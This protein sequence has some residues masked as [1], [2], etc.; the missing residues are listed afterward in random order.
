MARKKSLLS[1]GAKK[2]LSVTGLCGGLVLVASVALMMSERRENV[3]NDGTVRNVLL[4]RNTREVSLDAV[5]TS[6]KKLARENHELSSQVSA[7]QEQL[8]R[9]AYRTGLKIDPAALDAR[10]SSLNRQLQILQD[11]YKHLS[12]GRAPDAG[13]GRNGR[14]S[15]FEDAETADHPDRNAGP[16]LNSSGN[17]GGAAAEQSGGNAADISGGA[18]VRSGSGCDASGKGDGHCAEQDPAQPSAA[19]GNSA[20]GR[21]NDEIEKILFSDAQQNTA[22][23][24]GAG[25]AGFSRHRSRI[26]VYTADGQKNP[27][28]SETRQS[29][30]Q[31][32]YPGSS[33]Y[34][35]RG[36]QGGLFLPAGSIL[37]GVFLNGMD[38]PTGQGHG[39]DQFPAL[40]RLKKEA[41]LP[42]R[43]RSDIRECFLIVSGY[44]DLSSERAYLRGELISCITESRKV[45]EGNI[46]AYV[47]GPDGFA[48]VRGRL[49]SKQGQ[50]IAKS[51]MSGFLS[52]LSSAFDVK[53]VPTISTSAG[54]SVNYESLY[55]SKALQGAAAS[56]ISSSL[57]RI[58]DF[59]LKIAEGL[60]PVIEISAGKTVDVIVSKGTYLE[61]VSPGQSKMKNTAETAGRYSAEAAGAGASDRR[62]RDELMG[63]EGGRNAGFHR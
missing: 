48:G 25:S 10:L 8:D 40:I 36:G 37:S 13:S 2:I 32:S 3:R 30:V 38:A 23:G 22:A 31:S 44:G 28:G 35:G 27:A 26:T 58:A 54:G 52:G 55:S 17:A 43:F 39:K 6:L 7:L 59:Y 53:A 60:Y 47:V 12:S 57:N 49:V 18:G 45:I 56:G 15:Y 9:Q 61:A 11:Q 5:E 29:S 16:S 14:G 41:I 46:D 42:N 63:R 62:S 34:D 19:S 4:D 51:L 1:P 21:Q 50:I 33:D 20:S 24:A